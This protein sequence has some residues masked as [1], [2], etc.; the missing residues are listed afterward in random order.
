MIRQTPSIWP[1][2]LAARRPHSTW[3]LRSAARWSSSPSTTPGL[4]DAVR[5]YAD[6]LDGRVVVD[7]TNPVDT[8]TW[9]SLAIPLG[10]SSAEEV[11][12]LLPRARRW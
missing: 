7:I 2:S 1:G 9:D 6:R 11:R 5:Q 4:K 8:Q 12:Q 3:V 10:T